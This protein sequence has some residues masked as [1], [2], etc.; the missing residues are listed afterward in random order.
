M[1]SVLNF[2]P[3]KWSNIFNPPKKLKHF[4]FSVV[5]FLIVLFPIVLSCKKK[6]KDT[7][8]PVSEPVI[9]NLYKQGNAD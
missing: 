9:N 5:I 2:T 7:P 3:K 8:V 6:E 1:L 4:K